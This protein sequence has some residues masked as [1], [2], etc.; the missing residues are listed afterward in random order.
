ML[1]LVGGK[2]LGQPRLAFESVFGRDDVKDKVEDGLV[3]FCISG[4]DVLLLKKGAQLLEREVV[5]VEL[6]VKRDILAVAAR[7]IPS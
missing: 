6:A 1:K 7:Q 2:E 3:C 4:G 5:A